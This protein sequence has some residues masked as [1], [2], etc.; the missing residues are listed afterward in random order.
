[1]NKMTDK[2]VLLLVDDD[3]ENIQVV[4]SILGDKY[5]IRVAMNGVKAL[6]LAKVEPFPSLI[7][8]DVIMP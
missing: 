4:N 6:E 7:L 5:K 8:L 3:S 2:N 1:M